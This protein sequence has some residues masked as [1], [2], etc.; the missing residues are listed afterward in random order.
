M[1]VCKCCSRSVLC[2][3]VMTF[4]SL[5]ARTWTPRALEG[6]TAFPVPV[7]LISRESDEC[8]DFDVETPT[9]IRA[10]CTHLA[11]HAAAGAVSSSAKIQRAT[12]RLVFF[13]VFEA[14]SLQDAARHVMLFLKACAC[15]FDLLLSSRLDNTQISQSHVGIPSR[16]ESHFQAQ[17]Q[18]RC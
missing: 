17:D 16:W 14:R 13:F 6:A 5:V 9:D 11:S 12:S 4:L 3:D 1:L 7:T 2:R 15:E 8:L 18:G 10:K